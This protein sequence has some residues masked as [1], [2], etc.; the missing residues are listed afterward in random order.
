[1]APGPAHLGGGL[2]A[3]P[4]ETRLSEVAGRPA[5]LKKAGAMVAKG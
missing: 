5:R 1:M 4:L 3:R 2:E